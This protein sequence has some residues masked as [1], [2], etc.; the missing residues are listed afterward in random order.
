GYLSVVDNRDV[1]DD[2]DRMVLS[3]GADVCAV[4]LAKSRAIAFAVEQARGDWVQMWLSGTPADDDMLAT[5]AQQA[6]FE[7]D[8]LYLVVVYRA[9]SEVGS[10]LPLDAL[11]PLVRDDMT[12]RQIAGAVGQY[13]DVIV[14]LYP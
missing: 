4:E 14:A 3:Y 7:P 8:T 12:R 5:R 9:T 11:I 10:S 1:L 13:V 2:F 6:G